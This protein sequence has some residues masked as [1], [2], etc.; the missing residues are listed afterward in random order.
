MWKVLDIPPII[1]VKGNYFVLEEIFI[2]R[3]K[4]NKNIKHM[5]FSFEWVKPHIFGEVINK[6]YII[7]EVINR[8]NWRS[9][10]IGKDNFQGRSNSKVETENGNL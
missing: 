10:N 6:N 7:F 5:R 1:R 3:L 9:P 8:V 4:A 2:Q